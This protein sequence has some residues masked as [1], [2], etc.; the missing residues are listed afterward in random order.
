LLEEEEEEEEERFQSSFDFLK[1]LCIKQSAN[2][3][4]LVGFFSFLSFPSIVFPTLFHTFLLL[5]SSCSLLP[6]DAP[7]SIDQ[8]IVVEVVVVLF[9]WLRLGC[10]FAIVLLLLLLFLFF[11]LIDF[12]LFYSSSLEKRKTQSDRE[13]ERSL[14]TLDFR[15]K[16]DPLCSSM[17]IHHM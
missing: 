1:D 2:Q 8:L 15:F 17:S 14:M 16:M 6:L 3:S 7:D 13:C 10:L 11:D 12:S 4:R 5:S 9:D